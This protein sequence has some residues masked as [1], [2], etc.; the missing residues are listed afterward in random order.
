[1]ERLLVE[2]RVAVIPG[3][4]FGAC[5]EGFVRAVYAASMANIEEALTRIETFV[6]RYR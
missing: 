2:E 6:K 1:M 5:G 4:A 3:N